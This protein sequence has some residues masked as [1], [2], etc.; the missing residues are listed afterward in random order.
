MEQQT[1]DIS[2]RT[3][4]GATAASAALVALEAGRSPRAFA[5]KPPAT[6]SKPTR[7]RKPLPPGSKA[8]FDTVVVLMLENRSFDHLLGWVPGANGKQ[9]GLTYPDLTGAP[10]ATYPLGTD[11]Q[12][13]TEKDPWH[14]WETMV[15]H[16]NRGKVDGWLQTQ[17]TGDHFPIGY[18]EEAQVPVLG[19]LAQN[20]TLFDAY[21]CSLMGPT[22][23]NRFYQ[24]CAATD[25]D[26]SGNYPTSRT[27]RPS[28]IKLSIFDRVRGAGLKAGY[29]HWGQPMTKL[30]A[31]KRY[32]DIT[33]PVQQFFSDASA[34]TLPNVTF[35]EPDFTNLAEFVGTSNDYHP[36]GNIQVGEGY[37]ADVYNALRNSPQW[38]RMVF[39]INFDENGGF[40]D[41]VAPP[42]V[43]DNNHNPNP[44]P[45][46][47]YSRL[48]FR[49]PAI[50]V[51]PYAP[52]KIE[53]A[54]PYEHTSILKMIEWRWGLKPMTARDKHAKNLADALDF[55]TTRA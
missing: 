26:V 16:Y 19:A 55:S 24:L 33:Y 2:R 8:P 29:Y 4:L 6:G 25:Q 54:G 37:V 14:T 36:H 47:D 49:V 13:C 15:K 43:V 30:F 27:P 12:G 40:Y 5:A 3:F 44:G 23:P 45:H 39:V 48:G 17:T 18:Y 42:K 9:A 38:E 7:A 22:W 35:V 28:K 10:A 20:Y 41:H 34:G 53:K 50:A 32:D 46:P 51:G 21:H 52:K 11:F 31:S 1:S